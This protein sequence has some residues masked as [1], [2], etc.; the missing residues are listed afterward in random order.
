M[1]EEDPKITRRWHELMEELIA[2]HEGALVTV[3]I[4]E[5]DHLR[6]LMAAEQDPLEIAKCMIDMLY[7]RG[8]PMGEHVPIATR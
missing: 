4:N 8:T 6:V 3:I 5:K 7:G 1:T 2:L